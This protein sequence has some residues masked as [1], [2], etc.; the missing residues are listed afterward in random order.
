MEAVRAPTACSAALV[1]P[2]EAMARMD[3][4]AAWAET[5][6]AAAMIAVLLAAMADPGDQTWVA[7]VQV[8]LLAPF[9]IRLHSIVPR[10]VLRS[11]MMARISRGYSTRTPN[12][13]L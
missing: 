6:T 7:V 4:T 5:C 11:E 10:V 12:L 8:D 13:D 3:K 1:A 9:A 2:A